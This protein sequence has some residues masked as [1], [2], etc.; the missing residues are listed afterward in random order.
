MP[1]TLTWNGSHVVLSTGPRSRT[2]AN[3]TANPRVRLALGE[4]RDAV[5]V[6]AVLVEA[7]PAVGA[8]EVL[9][10]GYAAAG[11]SGPPD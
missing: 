9:A 5:L 1:V 11:G 6:D 3:V 10:E 4:T 2:V 7:V 8:P